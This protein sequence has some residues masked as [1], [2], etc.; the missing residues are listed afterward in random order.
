M[1]DCQRCHGDLLEFGGWMGP[2]R[3]APFPRPC[4]ACSPDLTPREIQIAQVQWFL[5]HSERPDVQRILASK[6]V[7]EAGSYRLV[8]AADFATRALHVPLRQL[9]DA[10]LVIGNRNIV[11]KD[12]YGLEG[13]KLSATERRR[14]QDECAE[15]RTL[16][17]RG[18]MM[19][20]GDL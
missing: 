7:L 13:Y 10:D 14:I 11:L 16:T 17:G 15:F 8:V 1:S 9:A 20:Y 3:A 2:T 6:A 5:A 12:R 4:P 19:T 18:E